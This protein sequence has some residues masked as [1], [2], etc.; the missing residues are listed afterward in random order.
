MRIDSQGNVGIGT[1]TTTGA[2]LTVQEQ[3]GALEIAR[4]KGPADGEGYAGVDV[5]G[6]S[7]LPYLSLTNSASTYFGDISGDDSNGDGV[8]LYGVDKVEIN[9]DGP[10]TIGA[11]V[12][13]GTTNPI[14]ILHLS[15]AS[16]NTRMRIDNT[17]TDGDPVINFR[18]PTVDEWTIGLDD[19]DGDKFKIADAD[20]LGSS[21]RL[22]IDQSGN[23]GIGTT[24]PASRLDLAAGGLTLQEMTAPAA[25]ASNCCVIYAED[26][27]SGKTRL[28]VRFPSGAAQQIAIEP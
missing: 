1:T 13:I 24:S 12:G 14:D 3:S 25:P 11:S 7:A 23:V 20:S 9:S 27:G 5:Q 4:F 22:T 15:S 19:S 28:M 8:I 18:L 17:A 16:G 2:Q 21:D 6:I 10:V 26:N